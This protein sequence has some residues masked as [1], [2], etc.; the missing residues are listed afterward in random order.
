M[1]FP[2]TGMPNRTF[3]TWVRPESNLNPN[4]TQ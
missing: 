1:V 2:G 3:V 4:P